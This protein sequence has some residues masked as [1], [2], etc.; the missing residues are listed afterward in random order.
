MSSRQPARIHPNFTQTKGRIITFRDG[1]RL[2]PDYLQEFV[3]V[4]IYPDLTFQEWVDKVANKRMESRIVDK[5]FG[6]LRYA[7]FGQR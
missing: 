1:P 3:K 2:V 7:N 5:A 4:D 6:M